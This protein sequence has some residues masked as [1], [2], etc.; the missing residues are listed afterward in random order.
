MV[1]QQGTHQGITMK[2]YDLLI[3]V[4]WIVIQT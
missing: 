4:D 2:L 3:D 1:A